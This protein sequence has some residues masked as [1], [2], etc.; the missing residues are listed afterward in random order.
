MILPDNTYDEENAS[1]DEMG[2]EGIVFCG[3]FLGG[4]GVRIS[5]FKE[6]EA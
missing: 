6:Y 2:S 4:G 3:V 1:A 5:P